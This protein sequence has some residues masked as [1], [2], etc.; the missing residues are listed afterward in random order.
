M[1]L[2]TM[3][4]ES[5]K[6]VAEWAQSLSL[7]STEE[8]P[9][10]L[11]KPLAEL[12]WSGLRLPDPHEHVETEWQ[13]LPEPAELPTRPAP[14]GWLSAVRPKYR[15]ETAHR[16]RAFA[17]KMMNWLAGSSER[18]HLVVI[19]GSWL[20]FWVHKMPHDFHSQPGSAIPVDIS[21]ASATHLNL[22]FYM[23]QG[24]GYPDQE[25]LSFLFLGVRY[26]ADLRV[27][28]VLQP[29]LKSFLPVQ[30][31]FLLESDR[32]LMRGWS[33]CLESIPIVPYFCATCGSVCRPLEPDRPRCTNDAGAPRKAV[34][35]EDGVRVIP[36]NEAIV[37]SL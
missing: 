18:P 5:S 28:I 21:K 33:V 22:N 15:K 30:E 35:D 24:E 7:L 26:K 1:K 23:Q 19:P 11:R 16:V 29:H 17:K 14:Q 4:E 20:E 12:E 34:V 6:V 37:S 3:L 10:A 2:N 9:A 27:Q 25:L 8:V 36:L 32:F 31:K 13:P